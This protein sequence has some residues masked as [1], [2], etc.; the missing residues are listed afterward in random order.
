MATEIKTT[1]KEGRTYRGKNAS[2]RVK[3]DLSIQGEKWRADPL[4]GLTPKLCMDIK[5]FVFKFYFKFV[6]DKSVFY[7]YEIYLQSQ[8]S[9]EGRMLR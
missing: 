5:V 1:I 6:F 7:L 4:K 9:N 2:K 3:S 8:E